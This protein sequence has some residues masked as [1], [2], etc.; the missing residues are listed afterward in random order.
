MSQVDPNLSLTYAIPYF[1]ETG[2]MRAPYLICKGFVNAGWQVTI[3][4]L[5][6][7]DNATIESAWDKVPVR[8]VDGPTKRIRLIKL[9][10]TFL[11][12][13]QRRL[14]MTFVWD[15]HCFALLLAKLAFGQPYVVAMDTYSHRS[16]KTVL[17]RMREAVR[18][19]LILRHASVILAEAPGSFDHARRYFKRP[20]IVLV[21]FCLWHSDLKRVERAWEQEGFHPQ[22]EPVILYAGR[23]VER[24][25]VHDLITA[26][27][28]LAQHY[29]EWSLE[30]R[31]PMT[32]PDYYAFLQQLVRSNDL[33]GR[34]NFLPSLSGQHLYRRYRQISIFALPS[35]GEGM[36]TT[37]TEASYFGGAIIAGVS[38][39]VPFQLAHGEC[40]LLHEPGDV[41][42]LTSHLAKL[43]AS[44]E[45]RDCYMAKARKRVIEQFTWEQ[46]FPLLEATFRKLVQP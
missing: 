24:K 33:T 16:A 39:G 26:F 18:Y 21:P 10:A 5:A 45:K 14:V 17:G 7:P 43:M 23:L 19:G 1:D 8:K 34:V 46:Y 42:I 44:K 4:A 22:R 40:G 36:P 25:N 35:G 6:A 28:C 20:Q 3:A 2:E 12:K 41:E 15:W 27:G 9:A 31:G 38:G 32:S 11:R 30:I 37:I 13:G 29:P